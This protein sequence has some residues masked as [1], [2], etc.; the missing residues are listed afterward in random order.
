MVTKSTSPACT[1]IASSHWIR[2]ETSSPPLL[3]LNCEITNTIIQ[4]DNDGKKKLATLARHQ[5]G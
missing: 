4:V 3:T 2:M 5:E 1:N